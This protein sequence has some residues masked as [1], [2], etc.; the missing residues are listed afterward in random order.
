MGNFPWKHLLCSGSV[1]AA[2]ATMPASAQQQLSTQGIVSA[3][4]AWE[5]TQNISMPCN[6][7]PLIEIRADNVTL[8]LKGF[9]LNCTDD[10]APLIE[11]RNFGPV[12]IRNGF[13][14]GG[15]K[16]HE[17][18]VRVDPRVTASLSLSER[19]T[20]RLEDLLFR[21]FAIAV[22]A[23]SGPG[24][25]VMKNC[26]LVSSR[27]RTGLE[28][29]AM[30]KVELVGNTIRLTPEPVSTSSVLAYGDRGVNISGAR[31][32]TLRNN[33]IDHAFVA[34][35]LS[36]V[37][38]G[39]VANN[40]IARS[41]FGIRLSETTRVA[42]LDNTLT[43]TELEWGAIVINDGCREN[44]LQ[45]NTSLGYRFGLSASS[46]ESQYSDN[47]FLAANG[48]SITDSGGNFDAG[49]NKVN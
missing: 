31:M 3:P 20:F 17:P 14:V 30:D 27:A 6:G 38:S 37:H 49:E 16:Q 45:R 44:S 11:A 9:S 15:P 33:S 40:L 4:G 35:E 10:S 46:A 39:V 5:V 2:A 22:V 42:I 26:D 18:L 32:V 29:G 21:E 34:V 24:S 8:D 41:H 47:R 1:I 19:M 23:D 12:V 28:A 25:I 13:L 7:V 43:A 48:A 36:G